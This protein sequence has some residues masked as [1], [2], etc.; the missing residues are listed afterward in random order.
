MAIGFDHEG[1]VSPQPIGLL[2][3]ESHLVTV[4][5]GLQHFNKSAGGV[6]EHCGRLSH[7]TSRVFFMN[8][9]QDIL[10]PPLDRSRLANGGTPR[11]SCGSDLR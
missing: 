6:V 2:Q 7:K 1:D 9:F 8:P 11:V 10:G 5:T 4:G 3:T